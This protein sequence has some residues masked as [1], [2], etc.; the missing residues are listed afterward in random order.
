[1]LSFVLF[2][3]VGF[4]LTW[5]TE[6]SMSNA[7]AGL[8]HFFDL[9]TNTYSTSSS[10]DY[11]LALHNIGGFCKL[12]CRESWEDPTNLSKDNYGCMK[13]TTGDNY[14][15]SSVS[16]STLF[17]EP[18]VYNYIQTGG[19]TTYYL[20]VRNYE[21]QSFSRV[22]VTMTYGSQCYPTV[23]K[24]YETSDM[25]MTPYVTTPSTPVLGNDLTF[26]WDTTVNASAVS[27]YVKV[28]SGTESFSPYDHSNQVDH[29]IVLSGAAFTEAGLYYFNV[30][31]CQGDY[32]NIGTWTNCAVCSGTFNSVTNVSSTQTCISGLASPILPPVV[33]PPNYTTPPTGTDAKIIS[34]NASVTKV[35]I[36]YEVLLT[37]LV[38]NNGSSNYNFYLGQSIGLNSTGVFCNRDCY[39][40]C[41]MGKIDPVINY[42]TYQCD[43]LRT[44]TTHSGQTVILTRKYLF[45]SDFFTSGFY[46]IVTA[47]YPNAY[48]TPSDA[49][50]IDWKIS[51][52]NVTN[53]A[54]TMSNLRTIPAL[55]TYV[56]G[57]TDVTFAWWTNMNSSTILE[58]R[59]PD[60]SFKSR[61][62]GDNIENTG[63]T[64]HYVTRGGVGFKNGTYTYIATSCLTIPPYECVTQN[65]TVTFVKDDQTDELPNVVNPVKEWLGQLLGIP[66]DLVLAFLGLVISVIVSVYAGYKTQDGRVV[67]IV[68]TVMILLFTIM[69]WIP[70]WILIIF[71]IIAAFIVTKWGKELFTG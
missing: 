9:D 6:Q 3:S 1:M 33:I 46:D 45:R 23:I 58:I 22:N 18:N 4:S 54:P 38:Q 37:T 2:S 7:A 32:L 5:T 61:F 48:M 14:Q 69:T 20:Y 36:G 47:I 17:L 71:V 28:P 16:A 42:G 50:D 40:D 60:G 44:E 19:T 41:Q 39:V 12:I 49:Y 68:M 10:I 57:Q 30:T 52:F 43:Y 55:T 66:A 26:T 64:A 56:A 62:T 34:V 51:Y 27:L 8:P 31:S 70:I 67:A 13:I 53:V 24:H 65:S 35:P 11:D 15:L 63:V 25:A 29:S 21:K 59:N